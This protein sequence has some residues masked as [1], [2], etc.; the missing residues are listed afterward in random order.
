MICDNCKVDR[1]SKDFIKNQ[2]FCYRCEY[3]KKVE[4]S[5]ETRNKKIIVCRMCDK[6]IVR[7]KDIKKRQR[8]VFCSNECALKGHKELSNNHWTRQIQI[9]GYL[10]G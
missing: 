9:K 1:D 6:E 10:H 7:K 2:K 3:R 4:K 8:S 5:P